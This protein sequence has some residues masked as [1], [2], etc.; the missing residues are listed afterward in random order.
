MIGGLLIILFIR[1]IDFKLNFF[2]K[3]FYFKIWNEKEEGVCTVWKI[4]VFIIFMVCIF[5]LRCLYSNKWKYWFN[6]F[7]LFNK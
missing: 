2:L 7:K 3:I 6:V 1:K 5:I 4:I